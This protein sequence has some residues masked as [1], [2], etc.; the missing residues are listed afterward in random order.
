[1]LMVLQAKAAGA[2]IET[3]TVGSLMMDKGLP[4]QGCADQ[5]GSM[6]YK[7]WRVGM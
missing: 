3:T 7:S 4:K 2:R 1:V 5:D 6:S